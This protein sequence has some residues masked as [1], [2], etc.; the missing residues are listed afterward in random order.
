MDNGG[1]RFS[2]EETEAPQIHVYGL[3]F[4]LY[5]LSTYY[6]ATGNSD[7]LTLAHEAF[8]GMY[9]RMTD[10]GGIFPES[11]ELDYATGEVK[12]RAHACIATPCGS[13]C[14]TAGG[15]CQ[16]AF[17]LPCYQQ[18]GSH[19]MAQIYLHFPDYTVDAVARQYGSGDALV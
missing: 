9:A 6:N 12:K 17:K 11:F 4:A 5:A 16:P 18:F 10:D 14:P 8:D 19:T 7:A 15:M 1:W 13:D 2:F 3:G